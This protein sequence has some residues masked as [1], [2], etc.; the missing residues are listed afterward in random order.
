MFGKENRNGI[1][2]NLFLA[3]GIENSIIRAAIEEHELGFRVFV[4]GNEN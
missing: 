1:R 3:I 2:A 4:L